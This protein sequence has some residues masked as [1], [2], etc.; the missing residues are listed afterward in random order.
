ML[1]DPQRAN[2]AS[3]A[4]TLHSRSS[5]VTMAQKSAKSLP[6]TVVTNNCYFASGHPPSA[7]GRNA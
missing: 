6:N 2:G 7:I 5:S 1:V 3:A 4:L